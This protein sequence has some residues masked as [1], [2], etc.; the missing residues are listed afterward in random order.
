MLVGVLPFF[1]ATL[2]FMVAQISW[3]AWPGYVHGA[4]LTAIDVIAAAFYLVLPRAGGR[5]PGTVLSQG[6]ASLLD[7]K[8]H[9]FSFMF[10]AFPLA[11]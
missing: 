9:S 1:L 5:L 11:R 6:S 2:H 4:E 8:N 3:A 10:P 7:A